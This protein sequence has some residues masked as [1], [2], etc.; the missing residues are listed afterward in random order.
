[1]ASERSA[2]QKSRH[3]FS[4]QAAGV[5]TLE[6]GNTEDCRIIDTS[7][8]SL[9]HYQK[10]PPPLNQKMKRRSYLDLPHDRNEDDDWD[11]G[12]YVKSGQENSPRKRPDQWSCLASLRKP[13]MRRRH[14]LCG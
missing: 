4:I 11:F 12:F 8:L 6:R 7:V 9:G 14:L 13:T 5:S 2:K 3:T 10:T 1:L